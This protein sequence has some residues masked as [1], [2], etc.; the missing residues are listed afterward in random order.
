MLS[1]FPEV[2]KALGGHFRVAN[3][4]VN[5][6]VTEVVLDGA[7]VVSLGSEK[8]TAGMPKLMGMNREVEPGFFP[9]AS[10]DVSN[11]S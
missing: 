9:S 11:G 5:V 4:V 10:D 2:F 1:V 6:L 8:I 3:C 7:G